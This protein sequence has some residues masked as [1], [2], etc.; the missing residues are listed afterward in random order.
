MCGVSSV[1]DESF[2]MMPL[3]F[4]GAEADWERATTRVGANTPRPPPERQ[5]HQ[6]YQGTCSA[7]PG[8]FWSSSGGV[9]LA[10]GPRSRVDPGPSLGV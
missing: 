8:A 3:L 1:A 9:A 6:A 2:W 4:W 5:G 10:H 7:L